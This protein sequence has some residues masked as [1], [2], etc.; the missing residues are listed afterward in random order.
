M[1]A[2]E[3]VGEVD[4]IAGADDEVGNEVYVALVIT[5]CHVTMSTTR[6]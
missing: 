5:L 2:V 6:A 3:S 4:D 1:T